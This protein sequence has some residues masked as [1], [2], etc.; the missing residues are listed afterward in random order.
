MQRF[1][2]WGASSDNDIGE[3]VRLAR[4]ALEVERDDADTIS[5]AA[6]TLF[7]LA[8][9]TVMAEA[10][11]DRVLAVNQNSALA[12]RHKGLIRALRN[13]TDASVE[14]Y[15]RAMRLSPFDPL[16]YIA[17]AGL[18]IAHL[19]ARRF[20]LAIEWSDRALHESPRFVVAMR[21]K[22]VANAQLGRIEQAR[23]ELDRVLK[24]DPRLTLAAWRAFAGRSFAPEL[25]DLYD[26][27]LRLAGLPE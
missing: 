4:L 21:T 5:L 22:V 10:V 27:G 18:G 2:G 16:G 24:I 11:L 13:E 14:A 15:D 23:A 26:T 9:E 17:A 20:E 25:M 3:S 1:Q 8:G 19:A 6:N 12:W 7:F